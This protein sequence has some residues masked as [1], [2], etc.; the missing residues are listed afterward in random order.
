MVYI[1]LTIFLFF[2]YD[3]LLT[4]VSSSRNISII[5]F[6]ICLLYPRSFL[7]N[8]PFNFSKEFFQSYYLHMMNNNN[9]YINFICQPFYAGRKTTLINHLK[10]DKDVLNG[11]ILLVSLPPGLQYN[12]QTRRWQTVQVLGRH[13]GFVTWFGQRKYFR[14]LNINHTE[15]NLFTHF[16]IFNVLNK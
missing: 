5:Q 14:F 11:V 3:V 15:R 12:N 4:H 8:T 16:S 13:I 6:R 10:Q 7:T 1:S 9:I 2:I